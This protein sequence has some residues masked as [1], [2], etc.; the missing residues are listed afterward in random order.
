MKAAFIF[1]G[2]GSEYKDMGKDFYDAYDKSRKVYELAEK[3]LKKKTNIN[4]ESN[5]ESIKEICFDENYQKQYTQLS[6]YL[7]E[8]AILEA[9]KSLSINAEYTCRIKFR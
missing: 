3:I 8:I 6:I 7:T 2:Q 4:F 1:P 9:V 5:V